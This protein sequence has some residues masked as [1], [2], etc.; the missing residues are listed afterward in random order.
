MEQNGG[1]DYE[2]DYMYGI[3]CTA[4]STISTLCST[5]RMHPLKAFDIDR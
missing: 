3:F 2:M 5:Y 1:M 4:D